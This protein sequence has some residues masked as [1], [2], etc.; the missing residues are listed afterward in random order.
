MRAGR[1]LS[2]GQ[3]NRACSSSRLNTRPVRRSTTRAA[4][5]PNHQASQQAQGHCPSLAGRHWACPAGWGWRS[6]PRAPFGVLFPAQH[7]DAGLPARV[8]VFSSLMAV[9]TNS[10]CLNH[11]GPRPSEGGEL[12]SCCL[13]LACQQ[14]DGLLIDHLGEQTPFLRWRVLNGWIVGQ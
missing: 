8:T 3:G 4:P 2:R 1:C 6:V 10:L 5:L 14:A 9:R 7:L 11:N 12:S 13:Q